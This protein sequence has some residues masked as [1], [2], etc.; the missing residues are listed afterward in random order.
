LEKLTIDSATGAS[1]NAYVVV[2]DGSPRAVVQINHGLAEHA[3]RY[4]RFQQALAE[5]GFASIAHDH[6]GHGYTQAP[7]AKPGIYAKQDGHR[8]VI[9]DIA[10]IH[11]YVRDRFENP[12]IVTFGHSAGGLMALNFANRYP[13]ASAALAV[14]NSNFS[15]D[16]LGRIALLLISTEARI[17]DPFVPSQLMPKLTFDA[18]NKQFAPNRTGFD[19]LNRDEAEVDAYVADE[20]CGFEA[21]VSMWRDI[22]RLVFAGV[23]PVSLAQLPKD[24]PVHL[25]GGEND[26]A[27][28]GGKATLALYDRLVNKGLR[29]V[30]RTILADTRHESLNELNRDETTA[31]F[32]AWLEKHLF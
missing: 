8:K 20:F 29:K 21:T 1:L 22:F 9:A 18:W 10:A 3:G 14:W 31:G 24:L 2:P 15:D 28:D 7:D 27:T 16:L 23:D 13:Q 4:G 19:W 5:A 17:R 26:P 12:P 30:D 6:R 25:L 32:I 11:G